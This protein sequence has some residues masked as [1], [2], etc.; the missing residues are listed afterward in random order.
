M[1]DLELI[2]QS[3]RYHQEAG[4]QAA[5]QAVAHAIAIGEELRRARKLLPAVE[6]HEWLGSEFGWSKRHGLRYVQLAKNRTAVLAKVGGDASLRQGL[7]ALAG[8]DTRVTPE[9]WLVVGY[10]DAAPPD[11]ANAAELVSAA[12]GWR[13]RKG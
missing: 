4:R 10:L 11:G 8:S 2:T 13:V 9:R 5:R 1:S 6:W 12:Q 3:V 7:A